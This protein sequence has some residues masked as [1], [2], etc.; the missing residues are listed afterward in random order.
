MVLLTCLPQVIQIRFGELPLIR[1]YRPR[2]NTQPGLTG[3]TCRFRDDIVGQIVVDM[4]VQV[5]IDVRY[6]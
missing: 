6:L 3:L 2:L 4:F 1:L 5:F